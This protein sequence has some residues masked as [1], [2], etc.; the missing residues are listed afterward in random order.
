MSDDKN[1]EMVINDIKL[2]LDAV[3]NLEKYDTLVSTLTADELKET[4]Y[5]LA[6]VNNLIDSMGILYGYFLTKLEPNA[7]AEMAGIK[8]DSKKTFGGNNENDT[9]RPF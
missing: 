3:T 5:S 4:L 2:L 9:N 1:Q 8:P 7:L 6:R